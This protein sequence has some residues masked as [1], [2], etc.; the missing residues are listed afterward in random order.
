MR[1]AFRCSFG[2]RKSHGGEIPKTVRPHFLPGRQRDKGF[3]RAAMFL[4]IFLILVADLVQLDRKAGVPIAGAL[5][6]G[7]AGKSGIKARSAAGPVIGT[8]PRMR[9]SPCR[10]SNARP[11]P[12]TKISQ[13][14]AS[15]GLA[16][17]IVRQPSIDQ[18]FVIAHVVG[19]NGRAH[20]GDHRSRAWRWCRRG[21][22]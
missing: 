14:I 21:V 7:Q 16:C 2:L 12:M 1:N 19:H 8:M 22:R 15:P 10:S 6:F 11:L 20:G 3:R 13:R 4:P 18:N 17:K 5:R 9:N